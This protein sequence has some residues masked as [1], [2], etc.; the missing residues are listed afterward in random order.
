VKMRRASFAKG[1]ADYV[2]YNRKGKGKE[3][4]ID[5]LLD[6]ITEL[7]IAIPSNSDGNIDENQWLEKILK[8]PEI[9]KLLKTEIK[10]DEADKLRKEKQLRTH[11]K[12]SYLE[13]REAEYR[14][15]IEID[16]EARAHEREHYERPKYTHHDSNVAEVHK[17]KKKRPSSKTRDTSAVFFR[18]SGNREP[19]PL[20]KQYEREHYTKQKLQADRRARRLKEQTR[21]HEE[22]QR[23]ELDLHLELAELRLQEKKNQE[24]RDIERKREGRQ[25]RTER[26]QQRVNAAK[27]RKIQEAEEAIAKHKLQMAKVEEEKCKREEFRVTRQHVVMK[28][29]SI[30][31]L[32]SLIID[33][34]KSQQSHVSDYSS[35]QV[36]SVRG[37]PRSLAHDE[38]IDNLEEMTPHD[39]NEPPHFCDNEEVIDSVT[40]RDKAVAGSALQVARSRQN[41]LYPSQLVQTSPKQSS[42][43]ETSP[44]G[45]AAKLAEAAFAV[46][47]ASSQNPDLAFDDSAFR[48]AAQMAAQ[49][50]P[51]DIYQEPV[52]ESERRATIPHP[53]EVPKRSER[54]VLPV[55]PVLADRPP[56]AESPQRARSTGRMRENRKGGI[57]RRNSGSSRPQSADRS[58]RIAG[59][60]RQGGEF[61]DDQRNRRRVGERSHARSKSPSI[62]S[63]ASPK[64][65]H[66][67]D[68][69]PQQRQRDELRRH[70]NPKADDVSAPIE[71]TETGSHVT[72]SSRLVRKL[73]DLLEEEQAVQQASSPTAAI[74]SNHASSLSA[75]QQTPIERQMNSSDSPGGSTVVERQLERIKAAMATSHQR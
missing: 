31:N 36:R 62:R 10:K 42:S 3:E 39:S 72:N 63:T 53:I 20:S 1:K 59:K 54:S 48:L 71:V 32:R 2:N 27:E 15:R 64:R 38:V 35:S 29:M 37:S 6:L 66:V 61:S 17:K 70:S 60:S 4:D 24:R 58:S 47:A 45:V 14:Q 8:V 21:Q 9:D 13:Q 34:I 68:Q 67:R 11:D 40:P 75:S 26:A 73:L 46:A 43:F 55:R 19:A 56:R 23:R 7:D 51:L 74:K 52:T 22:E 33:R 28:I 18:G 12:L 50:T 65:G 41:N 44:F 16:Q 30:P 49:Q 69:Q 57:P 5:G 25:E